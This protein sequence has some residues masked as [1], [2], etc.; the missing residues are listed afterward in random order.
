MMILLQVD[1]N[2]PLIVVFM[3][4]VT[5]VLIAIVGNIHKWLK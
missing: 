4:C 2:R 1:W 3:L 5:A